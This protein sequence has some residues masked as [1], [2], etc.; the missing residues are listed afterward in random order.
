MPEINKDNK[1]IVKVESGHRISEYVKS[2]EYIAAIVDGTLHDLSDV[3]ES[4]RD[5]VLIHVDSEE[6]MRIL[7]HSAAHLLA[8]AV[9]EIF[10]DA[11]PNAG[12]ATDDGFYYDF[13]M[14]PIGMEDLSKVEERM[15][16]I[17]S[18]KLKIEKR[19]LNKRELLEL[20]KNNKYKIDRIMENVKDGTSSTVYSQGEY[21]DFCRGPHVPETSYIKAFKLLSIASTNYRGD[22]KLESMVRI[23]GTAFPDEK[24]LKLYIKNREEAAKRDHRK[25]GAEMDLFVFNPDR[26]PGLPL[27]T[28]NGAFIRNQLIDFMRNLNRENGWMEV[29]T[30]HLFRDTMWKQSGHYAKYKDDMFLFT[31]ADGDEY[32]LKPMNC[33]GHITI[34]ENS[35]HSYRDMPVKMSEFGTVY[36]YEK[37]GEVGG[38][39]RPR[40]FTIDDGHAFLRP[41]QIKEEIGLT[42]DMIMKSMGIMLSGWPIS[43]DLSLMDKNH[44]ESYLLQYKCRKCTHIIEPVRKSANASDIQ[45]P[46][47]GS[48][49]LEPDFSVWDS[50]TDQLRSALVSRNIAFK[51]FEGEAAFY[52]PKIDVHVKDAFGRSW[53][54]STLQLDFNMPR[55]FGLYFINSES[56]HETPIMLHRAIFGSIER[57]IVI[58][59]ESYFGKLPTW[60]SPL[61]VYLI[62]VSE[63][64]ADYA[65][66]IEKMLKSRGIMC[67]LDLSSETVGK[68]IKLI[69]TKRPSYICVVGE[70]ERNNNTITVRNRKDSQVTLAVDEFINKLTKEINERRIEQSF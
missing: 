33:P 44:P 28:S 48:V 3:L 9:T 40:T 39:S 37:S 58:L 34:F 55:S 60:L 63:A 46:E 70:N 21:V 62:P 29:C 12:P 14:Q 4:G 10:P 6:G 8:Q 47:C 13:R 49:D 1:K 5:A 32:A 26:A 22:V 16:E 54:L 41:D 69:R 35:P 64:Y 59:L 30:P 51:E 15:R 17:S 25:I 56:K 36:R 53:Q 50:A 57:L 18:K 24:S 42:L 11:L 2:N 61:Q 23:Y 27:Y 20:F 38:L 19:E 65:S 31:L 43:F 68:K 52:G 7:R 67:I 45:C 66:E